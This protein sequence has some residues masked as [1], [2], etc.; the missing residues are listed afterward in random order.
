MI[1]CGH[2]KNERNE[3]RI[4]FAEDEADLNTIVTRKLTQSGFSVDS[5]FD[6]KE[7]ME[8]LD[9]MDYD[10]VVLDIMMP[11]ADGYQVLKF[12]KDSGKNVPVLFLTAK[13]AVSERVR[14]LDSGAHDYLVKPFSLE[15]LVA[16]VRAMIRTNHGASAS[17]LEYK[18]LLVDLSA[19]TVNR[20][21]RFIAL[22]A[23]EFQLLEYLL[24]N[25]GKVLSKEQIENHIWNFDYEGG[26]NV[27]E[28][29]ISYLRKKIDGDFDEK[30][31]CT[32]RGA[33]YVIR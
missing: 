22:S 30:L 18:D 1:G 17:V 31:I 26:T 14:G 2:L 9:M 24:L 15:E 23:K 8:Y 11:R 19:H 10:A 4:L 6:G 16:R 25:K 27:V 28:V 5:C 32:V 13:D 21:G 3:M 33:G 29:Y 12:I 7:A 20:A